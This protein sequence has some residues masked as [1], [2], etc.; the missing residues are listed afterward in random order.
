MRRRFV[1]GAFAALTALA[2][3]AA[4]CS[5]SS[6][7]GGSTTSVTDTAATIPVTGPATTE[8]ITSTSGATTSEPTST[9]QPLAAEPV[10]VYFLA[11]ELL[12][13]GG[14]L[15]P[16]ATPA[17]AVE[18]LLA[19][20]TAD[21][22]ADGLVSL[23]PAGTRLL[24][25]VVDG[26]EAVVDLSAE[27]NSGGGSLSVTGRVAQVVYTVTHFAGIDTVR[28]SIDGS[29]VTELTGEGL[30]VTAVHRL[31][32]VDMA[33]FILL[34]TPWDGQEV[35]SPIVV[36]GMSNTFEA[37]VNYEVL[38]PAGAVLAEGWFMATSG[39]GTWG[40]F[41]AT[42]APLPAG[43]T[44][45]VVVRLFEVSPENGQHVSVHEVTVRLA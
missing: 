35:S 27:F 3:M 2:V 30:D 40:T 24:G 41:D 29:I 23:V 8:V 36:T 16:A 34:E 12:H 43:T 22:R 28:F 38:S 33:P 42:L 19:G 20:P 17:A 31:D 37:Q 45:E 6:T 11:G 13:V 32:L 21:E 39:T 18:A 44:G 26:N 10:L 7:S 14:R 15:V 25:L 9:T 5:D 1:P 4:G